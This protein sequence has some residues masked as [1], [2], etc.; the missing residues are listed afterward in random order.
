MRTLGWSVAIGIVLSQ[1][2]SGS[3]LPRLP[4]MR[5]TDVDTLVWDACFRGDSATARESHA[6]Q[7]EACGTV[8]LPASILATSRE[9]FAVGSHTIALE[10]LGL[11]SVGAA[12]GRVVAW[13]SVSDTLR[14]HLDSEDGYQ[15]GDT[16]LIYVNCDSG[17]VV[18]DLNPIGHSFAGTWGLCSTRGAHGTVWFRRR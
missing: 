18:A 12:R 17:V 1:E 8:R 6:P 4:L 10:K 5:G 13:R 11:P 3:S 7:H 9:S 16:T 14:L 2:S 15:R